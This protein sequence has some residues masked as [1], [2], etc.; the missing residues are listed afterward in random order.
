MATRE[1]MRRARNRGITLAMIARASGLTI[2]TVRR[3]L[4]ETSEDSHIAP[5][6]NP[7]MYRR[8]SFPSPEDETTPGD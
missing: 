4:A 7:R 1:A 5:P 2:E 6:H 8:K 3:R